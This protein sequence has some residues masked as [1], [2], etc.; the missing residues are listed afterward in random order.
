MPLHWL[1]PTP[2]LQADLEPNEATASGMVN[3][4]EIFD[5]NVFQHRHRNHLLDFL[6]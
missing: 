6:S 2:V 3:Q 5:R 4:L 1:F